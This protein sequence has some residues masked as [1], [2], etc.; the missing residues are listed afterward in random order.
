MLSGFLGLCAFLL[1]G[2]FMLLSYEFLRRS[3]VCHS[4]EAILSS[5]G[6]GRHIRFQLL[7]LFFL[8]LGFWLLIWGLCLYPLGKHSALPIPNELHNNL[9]Y[10]TVLYAFLP[11]LAGLALG[12]AWQG[13]K[14][15]LGFYV[16]FTVIVFFSGHLAED[17]YH[18][19]GSIL[20]SAVSSQAGIFVQKL[21]DFA[22]RIQPVYNSVP[23]CAYGIGTEPYRWAILLFW[24]LGALGIFLL[25][26]ERLP[27]KASGAS[28]VALALVLGGF[29]WYGDHDPQEYLVTPFKRLAM[30]D[31]IY[32]T[33]RDT[34]SEKAE[35]AVEAYQM[36]LS[37]FDRLSAEVRLT[38]EPKFLKEYTFTLYH[39]Y[40]VKHIAD[41]AGNSLK[42]SQDRDYIT[43]YNSMDSPITELYFSYSGYHQNLYSNIQGIYLPGAL[44]FYPME[45][46]RVITSNGLLSEESR[47][48]SPRYYDV[49]ISF[50]LPVFT[51]LPENRGTYFCGEAK[52]LSIVGGM[53]RCMEQDE[54]KILLPWSVEAEPVLQELAEG[55]DQI[56]ERSGLPISRPQWNTIIYSPT[57]SLPTGG[58]GVCISMGDTLHIG[59]TYVGADIGQILYLACS[60]SV[61]AAPDNPVKDWY[62]QIMKD[63]ISG[64]PTGMQSLKTRF[65]GTD[66]VSYH[67]PENLSLQ[68]QDSLKTGCYLYAVLEQGSLPEQMKHMEE[69]LLQNNGE[70]PLAFAQSLWEG[71][72]KHAGDK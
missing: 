17:V 1:L 61:A 31:S 28:L 21:M 67:P 35:F 23:N 25:K 15:R 4:E 72:N 24:I 29:A 12:M 58:T 63:V 44:P 70:D 54:I 52:E 60:D 2:L 50:P 32:Y 46:K 47:I 41:G 7:F 51:N 19:L 68:E 56:E 49:E 57:I 65:H 27:G 6:K 26:E 3:S 59:T 34:E 48:L 36:K 8:A 13:K 10:A 33:N 14:G 66:P 64:D 53:Y 69:W 55:L 40:Q 42:F 5:Q 20:G 11:A 16:F 9:F 38:L 30:S 62:L 37:F 71:V 45:G 18:T 43:V 39:G 22:Y